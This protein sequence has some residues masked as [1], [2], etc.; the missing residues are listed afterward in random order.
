MLKPT[1]SSAEEE[2][3]DHFPHLLL[4]HNRAQMEDFSPPRYTMMQKV[5]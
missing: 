1:I 4:L 3:V 5:M 2:I